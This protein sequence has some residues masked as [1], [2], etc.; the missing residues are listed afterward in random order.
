MIIAMR[1]HRGDIVTLRNV[2][3]CWRIDHIER[4]TIWLTGVDY[5]PKLI[6]SLAFPHGIVA[7]RRNEV[8]PHTNQEQ[9]L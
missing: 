2:Q 6:A 5:L 4:N 9:L 8:I 1:L 3:G 7:V